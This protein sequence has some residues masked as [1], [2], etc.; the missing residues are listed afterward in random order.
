MTPILNLFLPS[1]RVTLKA[2]KGAVSVH[3]LHPG[4][5]NILTY[6]PLECS[7]QSIENLCRELEKIDNGPTVM[8]LPVVRRP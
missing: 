2:A 3:Q 8:F 6:D 4:R 7:N 5:I 1:R